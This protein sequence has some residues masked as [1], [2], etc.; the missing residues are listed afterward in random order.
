MMRRV[1]TNQKAYLEEIE[2]AVTVTGEQVQI[3]KSR[4]EVDVAEFQ[5]RIEAI[6]YTMK[7][8][9]EERDALAQVIDAVTSRESPAESKGA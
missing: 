5:D 7:Q 9:Q 4:T 8:L 1:V 2:D 3:V 6:D